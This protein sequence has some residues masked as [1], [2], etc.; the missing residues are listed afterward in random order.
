ME[1]TI[2]IGRNTEARMPFSS[3]VKGALVAIGSFAML[4]TVAALWANP[5]FIRMTPTSG[6][7]VGLLA[8]QAILLG[9]YVTI[10][11]PACALKLASLGGIANYIGI[12]CPICNKLLL[13][14]FGA[15]ALLTYLEPVRIYLAA[16]GALVTMVAVYVRWRN[17]RLV[18]SH[19]TPSFRDQPP[20]TV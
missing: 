6:F 19:P 17:F 14:L 10:P 2:R 15:S 12:A 1:D 11:V 5:F 3:Y 9:I 4:G 13:F 7:E 20:A 8:L 16:G 18:S